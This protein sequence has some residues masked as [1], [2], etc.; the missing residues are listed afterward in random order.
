MRGIWTFRKVDLQQNAAHFLAEREEKPPVTKQDPAPAP[1][2]CGRHLLCRDPGPGQTGWRIAQGKGV[3]SMLTDR[4]GHNLWSD[5]CALEK[6]GKE[7][8]VDQPIPGCPL[9]TWLRDLSIW[10]E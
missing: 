4:Q 2:Q 1:S 3:A 10:G 5:N 7:S 6:T 9:F 8:T